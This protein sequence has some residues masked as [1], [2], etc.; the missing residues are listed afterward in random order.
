MNL[1]N[2]YLDKKEKSAFFFKF[3]GI[4]QIGKKKASLCGMDM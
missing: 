4:D 3:Y 2:D 1:K